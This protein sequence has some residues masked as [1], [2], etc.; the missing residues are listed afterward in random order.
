MIKILKRNLPEGTAAYIERAENRRY[1]TGF[2]SSNGF[3]FVTG[4]TAVFYTDFRYITAAKNKVDKRVEVRL[5]DKNRYDIISGLVKKENINTVLIEENYLSYASAKSLEEAVSPCKIKA[6]GDGYTV[7]YRRVKNDYEIE[8]IRKAQ[9]IADRGFDFL[10]K[11]ISERKTELTEKEAAAKLEYFMKENGAEDLA[12]SVISAFGD[13]T[14]LPH[15]VPT[16][17][18][19]KEGDALLFDYGAK[20]NGY[21]SDITRTVFFKN[22]SEKQKTVYGIVLNAQLKAL[23]KI[24]AGITGREID[25]AA[26]DYIA[27]FGYASLFGHSLGHS[28]GLDIHE[29]PNYSPSENSVIAENNV[30]TIEPGIYIEGEFGVR[31]EDLAVVKNGGCEN[32]TSSKKELII[33]L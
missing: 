33:L 26:R 25:A 9:V 20:I 32:L 7:S 27:S 11:L 21:C 13:N 31:I 12:F 6:E 14:A 19:L 28:V 18:K 29:S 4:N 23:G 16:E 30:I 24:K 8:S 22:A 10:L 1:Y 3:L 2:T 17:R 15:A 5:L